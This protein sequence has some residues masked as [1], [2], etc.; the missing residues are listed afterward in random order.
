MDDRTQANIMNARAL[1]SLPGEELHRY[2]GQIALI[3]DG[4][5]EGYFTTAREALEAGFRKFG[6][7]LFSVTRVETQPVSVGFT[8]CADYPG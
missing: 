1:A 8:D 7:S 3:A 5:V 2:K 6:R 4:T